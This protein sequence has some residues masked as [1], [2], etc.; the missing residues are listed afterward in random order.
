MEK[1]RIILILLVGMSLPLCVGASAPRYNTERI[2]T[3]PPPTKDEIK[4]G[5]TAFK[6]KCLTITSWANINPA[7]GAPK[8]EEIADAAPHAKSI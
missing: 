1:N 2:F 4:I 5:A 6:E 7:I 8:P 3:L